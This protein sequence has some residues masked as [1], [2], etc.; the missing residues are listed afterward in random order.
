MYLT[1]LGNQK[2]ANGEAMIGWNTSSNTSN[3][4]ALSVPSDHYFVGYILLFPDNGGDKWKINGT[5]MSKIWRMGSEN[6]YAGAEVIPVIIPPGTTIGYYNDFGST[7]FIW[8][9]YYNK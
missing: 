8:G 5:W 9:N 7:F 6:N 2:P 3:G 4:T 1:D